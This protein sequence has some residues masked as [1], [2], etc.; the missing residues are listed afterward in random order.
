[1]NGIQMYLDAVFVS[2]PGCDSGEGHRGTTMTQL[3]DFLLVGYQ[4]RLPRTAMRTSGFHAATRFLSCRNEG[5]KQLV[6]LYRFTAVFGSFRIIS[7]RT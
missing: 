5:N 2:E 7:A 3:K 4:A 6:N 1:M